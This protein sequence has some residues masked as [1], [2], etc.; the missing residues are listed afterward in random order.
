MKIFSENND[1]S[2]ASIGQQEEQEEIDDMSDINIAQSVGQ[3][4]EVANQQRE[5][6]Q[7]DYSWLIAKNNNSQIDEQEFESKSKSE[8]MIQT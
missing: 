6:E 5:N 4:I 8:S 2:N 7:R 3:S 1:P